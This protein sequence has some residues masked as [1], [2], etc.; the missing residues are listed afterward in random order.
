MFTVPFATFFFIQ[1]KY[2]SWLMN[3]Y[4]DY[5]YEYLKPDEDLYAGLGAVIAT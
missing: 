4:L 1:S 5:Y 3:F 2:F